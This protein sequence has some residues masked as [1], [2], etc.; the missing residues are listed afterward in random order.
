MA[1][2]VDQDQT[3]CSGFTLFASMLN[4]SVM[5][6]NYCYRETHEKNLLA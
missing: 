5:L 3:V 1:N 2:R 6:G 4:S